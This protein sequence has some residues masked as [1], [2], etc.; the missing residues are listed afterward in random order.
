MA[1]C[2]HFVSFRWVLMV[3]ELDNRLQRIGFKLGGCMSDYRAASNVALLPALLTFKCHPSRLPTHSDSDT[4]S[5]TFPVSLKTLLPHPSLPL[6]VYLG[7]PAL[8]VNPTTIDMDTE[9]Y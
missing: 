5:T 3:L 2:L 4:L 1:D 6:Q 8:D 9:F 7:L